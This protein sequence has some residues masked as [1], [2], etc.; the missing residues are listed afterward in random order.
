MSL[1]IDLLNTTAESQRRRLLEALKA[2]PVTTIAAR[3]ELNIMMPA[4]RVNELKAQ[5]HEIYTMRIT[6]DDDCG[7]PHR[8]IAKY[9]L[10]KL[11]EPEGGE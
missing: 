8:Q 7:R 6:I 3:A 1:P 9:V 4:A 2:G 10:V 11:A 5:G